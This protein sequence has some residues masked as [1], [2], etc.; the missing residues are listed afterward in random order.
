MEQT[1]SKGASQGWQ[2]GAGETFW[3]QDRA[4]LYSWGN[5]GLERKYLHCTQRLPLVPSTGFCS[6]V[7]LRA[8][9]PGLEPLGPGHQS[10]ALPCG[11]T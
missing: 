8:L 10:L 2:V 1:G 9:L 11:V 4:V 3:G 5:P 7:G 6:Q